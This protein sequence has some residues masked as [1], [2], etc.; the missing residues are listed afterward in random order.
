MD[1][2]RRQVDEGSDPP[3]GNPGSMKAD[4]KRTTVCVV[5]VAMVCISSQE[6]RGCASRNIPVRTGYDPAAASTS[7][8]SLGIVPGSN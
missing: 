5:R 4:E 3:P 2:D 7:V 1:C 8:V 6:T